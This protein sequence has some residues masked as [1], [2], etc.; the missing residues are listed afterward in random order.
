MTSPDEDERTDPRQNFYKRVTI[1][2][3]DQELDNL[4]PN[5][6]GC[7]AE[8]GI[9]LLSTFLSICLILGFPHSIVCRL[10]KQH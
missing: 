7:N 2:D 5:P 9:L 1:K 3:D 8:A 10:R 4:L 6:T